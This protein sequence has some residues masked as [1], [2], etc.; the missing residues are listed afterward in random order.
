MTDPHSQGLLLISFLEERHQKARLA[1][2]LPT[3]ESP[4]RRRLMT[5]I[6]DLLIR[7]GTSIQK[8]G[9]RDPNHA[10][11]GIALEVK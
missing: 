7:T 4:N 1:E 11:A 5:S 3:R 8:Y 9:Q 2:R 6:G 10:S